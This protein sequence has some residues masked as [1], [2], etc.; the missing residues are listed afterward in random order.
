[1]TT[2]LEP[3]ALREAPVE[4]V[5]ININRSVSRPDRMFRLVLV[6]S[7]LV[8]LLIL[9]AVV[10]FLSA[11]GWQALSRGGLHFLTDSTWSP[12][13]GHYGAMPLLV[14][15]VAI[16]VVAVLIAGP[17]LTGRRADDQRVRSGQDQV[18]PHQ[19][20][21]HAGHC[22][23]HRLRLLGPR[24]GIE[25]PGAAGQVAG[26]SFR[27]RPVLPDSDPGEFVQ[28]IFACGLV[29]AAT[30]VPI[31][32]SVS[33]EVMSQAPRDAAARPRSASGGPGGEWSPTSSSRSPGT[34]SS[35]PSCSDSVAGWVR[36]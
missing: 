21:R 15:S 33:R 26:R 17:D 16:A 6:S 20:R 11:Y 4:D 32:T 8:V 28:S 3:P 1:M 10:A 27:L 12:D 22:A 34:A 31:I 14:G 25:P 29:S 24:V 7:S 2:L 9:V 35:A 13:S 36:R 5:P 30:I 23:Q 19:H 18:V